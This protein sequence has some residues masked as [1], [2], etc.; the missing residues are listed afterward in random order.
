M[1]PAGFAGLG[2]KLQFL[3]KDMGVALEIESV[4]LHIRLKYTFSI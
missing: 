2:G 1:Q 4:P 3:L